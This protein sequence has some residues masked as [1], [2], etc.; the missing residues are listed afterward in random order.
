M[1]LNT[2]DHEGAAYFG[3]AFINGNATIKGPTNGLFIK[4]AAKSE[5]GS[6]LKIPINDSENVGENSFI[7]FLTPKEKYNI[8]KGILTIKIPPF[9]VIMLEGK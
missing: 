4:V 6:A 2:V 8:K 5:K 3:T 7:H 9:S 1:V